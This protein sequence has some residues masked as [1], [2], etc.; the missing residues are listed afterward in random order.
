[1]QLKNYVFILS[2]LFPTVY[3]DDLSSSLNLEIN[4][5]SV[6][7]TINTDV[8]KLGLSLEGVTSSEG[9]KENFERKGEISF[10]PVSLSAANGDL[11]VMQKKIN[12]LGTSNSKSFLT[13]KGEGLNI[14]PYMHNRNSMLSYE[15]DGVK[16]TGSFSLLDAGYGAGLQVDLGQSSLS[17]HAGIGAGV[18]FGRRA[19]LLDK[20]AYAGAEL[21]INDVVKVTA[22]H[23]RR[24]SMFGIGS[25]STNSLEASIDILPSVRIGAEIEN[26]NRCTSV[27]GCYKVGYAGLKIGGVF[28]GKSRSK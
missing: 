17:A 20:Y 5:T 9:K 11:V 3:A 26:S 23:E 6:M 28:G 10:N 15:S 4:E 12:P 24:S 2:F 18:E 1:M 27:N 16:G 21:D 14:R 25:E 22:D 8:N 13:E 7:G 19:G